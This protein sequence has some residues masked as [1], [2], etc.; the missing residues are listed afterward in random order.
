V[1]AKLG[2]THKHTLTHTHTLFLF[3]LVSQSLTHCQM[4][5][6]CFCPVNVNV[7]HQSFFSI[8]L[9]HF[10]RHNNFTFQ[11]SHSL[12]YY[13]IFL[14]YIPHKCSTISF[15]HVIYV[16]FTAFSCFLYAFSLPWRKDS[17]RTKI[18]SSLTGLYFT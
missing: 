11:Y 7:I 18:H 8:S 15:F 6:F 1:R 17:P 5:L 3:F 13:F 10:P 14:N 9:P 16:T 4:V 12:R 2:A